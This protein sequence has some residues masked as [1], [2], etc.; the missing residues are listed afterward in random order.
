MWNGFQAGFAGV[1]FPINRTRTDEPVNHT[2]SCNGLICV[3]FFLCDE[4]EVGCTLI[5]EHWGRHM[6][7][8]DSFC[9]VVTHHGGASFIVHL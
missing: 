5:E 4:S 3:V 7:H 2:V 1:V 8:I 6:E 9:T